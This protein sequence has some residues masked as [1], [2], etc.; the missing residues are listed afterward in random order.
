MDDICHY[1]HLCNG[2]ELIICIFNEK[3]Q[4]SLCS[5]YRPMLGNSKSSCNTTD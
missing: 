1:G 5:E 4:Q 2:T 3:E